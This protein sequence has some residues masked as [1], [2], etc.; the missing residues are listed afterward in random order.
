MDLNRLRIAD[1]HRRP[2]GKRWKTVVLC[3]L[4]LGVGF[5]S[6]FLLPKPRTSGLAAVRTVVVREAQRVAGRRFTAGGWIEVAVPAHPIVISSR[7]PGE[8]Q[9]MLVR[10]GQML[11]PGQVIGRLYD[12][13]VRSRLALTVA[14][15]ESA[16]TNLA[17]MEAGYRKEDIQA[18]EARVLG[19]AEKLRVAKASY[20]R[21]RKAMSGSVT[22]EELD[23]SQGAFKK[24]EAEHAETQAELAKMRAGYRKED[25]AMARAELDHAREQVE[26]ARRELSYCTIA[27]P[28]DEPPLRVLKV[29]RRVGEYLTL[30]ERPELV[31]LYDPMR[32]QARADVTQPNI[33]SVVVGGPA[34]VTT[35]AEPDKG[36]KGRVL[37]VE[38]MAELSKNTVTVRGAIADPDLT[39]FPEMV[40]QITFLPQGSAATGPAELLVPAEALLDEGGVHYV[41]LREG[42]HVR[43]RK[44]TVS[45]LRG[46]LAAVTGGLRSGQRV[47]VGDLSALR[48]GQVVEE[49]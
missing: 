1:E 49:N 41:F 27:A 23:I 25:I 36:Y 45:S 12:K 3:L 6:S 30:K 42:R 33:K 22:E 44:V 47:I 15:H 31:W 18:A 48:D 17:K 39:R 16:R 7:I 24:A 43:R 2:T 4:F 40:A 5:A 20:E 35:E 9:E 32:M 14:S 19:L 37:R 46:R 26:L 28:K 29:V 13:D 34:L 8:L 38:P 21:T 10:E 11:K